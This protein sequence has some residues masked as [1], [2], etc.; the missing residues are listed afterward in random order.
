MSFWN[1]LRELRGRPAA[2]GSLRRPGLAGRSCRPV[3]EALE[4]RC[5]LSYSITDLG[6][7]GGSFSYAWGINASG[8]VVGYSATAGNAA[9]H[10]FL[11]DATVTPAMQDLG[12]L[13]GRDSFANGI[14]EIGR[15]H[16]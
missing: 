5:L 1:L 4:D 15:A 7:L 14:N 3:L 8:Q 10:A 2:R 13:G 16:V 11:Y 9:G 12:T 6:T